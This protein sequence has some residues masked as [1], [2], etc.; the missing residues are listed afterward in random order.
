MSWMS[1]VR[2]WLVKLSPRRSNSSS[3]SSSNR[4]PKTQTSRLKSW[5]LEGRSLLDPP[6]E[7]NQEALD[8]L[9]RQPEWEAVIDFFG[10]DRVEFQND[11][12]L[13]DDPIRLRNLATA[14]RTAEYYLT[15]A[16]QRPEDVEDQEG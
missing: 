10:N 14:A 7:V 4:P 9:K 11:M 15:W 8:H 6:R 12:L 16:M 13:E 5:I 1:T 3:P 2:S